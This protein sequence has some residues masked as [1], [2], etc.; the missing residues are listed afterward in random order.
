LGVPNPERRRR[1]ALSPKR[2]QPNASIPRAVPAPSDSRILW[3]LRYEIPDPS[4]K[5]D[6]FFQNC[7]LNACDHTAV[8]DA[9]DVQTSNNAS[10]ASPASSSPGDWTQFLRDNMQRWNPYETAINASNADSLQ[11]K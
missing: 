5:A 2:P 7:G 3:R 11:L 8:A 6:R 4:Q 1:F 9:Q 10:N